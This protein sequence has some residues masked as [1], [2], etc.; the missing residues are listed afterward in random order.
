MGIIGALTTAVSGL[1]TQS[2]ALENISGN[3]A[4]S[5][6][7]AFKR[8]DTSFT[9]LIPDNVPTRQVSGAVIS[10]SRA[11]NTVQGD[12][13]S[14]TSGTYMALNGEGYF[15]VANSTSSAGGQPVF[16]GTDL[17]T[18]RGDF[19]ID[20][21]GY[22]VNGAGYYLKL[23][24]IDR[25]TGNVSGSVPEVMPLTNDILPARAT[26]VIQYGANLPMTP[27]SGVL[28]PLDF[29]SDP[30]A[31]GAAT[32]FVE[33]GATMT[34]GANLT[35]TGAGGTGY[36]T[37]NSVLTLAVNGGTAA[38]F[39]IG[40]P[41]AAGVYND[42]TSLAN[43][44]N[45]DTS[46]AGINATV[47]GG[48]QLV[49]SSESP[50]NTLTASGTAATALGIANA[51][52]GTLT[53]G[54]GTIQANESSIFE[55]QSI[56][57]DAVTVYNA[58][59]TPVNVQLRWAK[60]DSTGTGGQ[61]TWN[62]FYQSDSTATGTEPMWTNIGTNFTFGPDSLLNPPSASTTI[63]NL[64][65]DG[66]SVGNV[67][68]SYGS[69]GLTQF[70]DTNNQQANILTK[71]QDGYAAG[72]VVRVQIS[73]GGRIT[74]FY[75]NGQMADIAEIPT[76]YFNADNMLKRMDGG[77]FAAT[78]E[79]GPPIPGAPGSII[80]SS[81]EGSNTDIADEFT[82]LIVTQQAYSANTRIVSTADEM[83]QE[84]L[85]MVR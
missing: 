1:R 6:T 52:P 47:V 33:P 55:A 36:V 32:P 10:Q 21:D 16:S 63:S 31:N 70:S 24:P 64:T 29:S 12:I 68:L 45:A 69:K 74:A 22:L 82:K 4:N 5:Q 37:N 84:A 66:V 28:S 39:T 71:N 27:T 40:S 8:T 35:N 17:Y 57:G 51:A 60:V 34:N 73:D 23:L 78:Y 65:V 2:Y 38:N 14:A 76:V 54:A 80:G 3:S 30:R 20:K 41:A 83:L 77:A 67:T 7:T 58:Q 9:D 46:L 26:S 53:A 79:S 11:T 42:L 19:D 25:Q 43:A 18:R 61:D 72:E 50:N 81:L 15:V 56:G 49:I 62:L 75:S 59:G 48:N 85:N 44:I 13:Q